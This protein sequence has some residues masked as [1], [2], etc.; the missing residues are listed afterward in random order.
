M[1]LAD[2]ISIGSGAVLRMRD[3]VH[4]VQTIVIT[5][6]NPLLLSVNKNLQKY[7][8]SGI[9]TCLH[10]WLSPRVPI[11]IPIVFVRTKAKLDLGWCRLLYQTLA[12]QIGTGFSLAVRND[13]WF[14]DYEQFPVFWAYG[15]VGEIPSKEVQ[16]FNVLQRG[17]TSMRCRT[18]FENAILDVR[19]TSR[20]KA[21]L[22]L[23]DFLGDYPAP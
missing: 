13:A 4:G 6:T 1:Y 2:V 19:Q 20:F 7:L 21:K 9:S 18:T 23:G 17:D 15:H 12:S 5:G 11:S 3:P 14:L 22:D 10:L 16:A 8:T